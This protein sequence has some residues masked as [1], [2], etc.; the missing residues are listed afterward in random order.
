MSSGFLARAYRGDIRQ[1]DRIKF[2]KADAKIMGGHA[3]RAMG[4][5][6]KWLLE[7]GEEGAREV[8]ILRLMGLFDRPADIGCLHA[9]RGEP[10]PDLT[11]PIAALSEEDWEFA[12]TGL[13]KAKLLT[14]H[15]DASGALISLDAHPLLREYFA[16]RLQEEHPAA[17][18]AAHKRL[19]EHL[20][21]T[22]RDRKPEPTLA[23]LQPLYQAVAH[24]CAAG[25]WQEACDKV[26][27]ERI[28]HRQEFYS[29]NKLGAFGADLGA[30]ACFFD[31]PWSAVSP[32]LAPADQSWLLGQAAFRLRALGRLG[33]AVAPTQAGL[34]M[35]AR[36]ED[37][38]N[39]AATATNLSELQL[40]LGEMDAAIDR[41]E[42]LVAHA[43][44]SGEMF[45]RMVTRTAR[46]DALHQARR[47]EEATALFLYAEALQAEYEPQYPQL[48]SLRGFRYCDLLLGPIERAAWRRH[49]APAIA[50]DARPAARF[51]HE[52]G[53]RSIGS[54][55]N[56]PCTM[57]LSTISRLAVPRFM[58]RCCK[59]EAPFDLAAAHAPL[60]AAGDGLRRAGQLHY[61][62]RGLPSRA[63]LRAL[64]ADPAGAKE[65]LDEA[66]EI[67]T[68]GPMPLFLADIHLH[69]ARLFGLG[70][71]AQKPY[72]WTSPQADLTEARRFI[73]KHGYWRRKE[74]LEDAEAALQ[75]MAAGS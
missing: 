1:R 65:D 56:L 46:A 10:I 75:A 34:E 64:D 47:V 23:D 43:E 25:M 39:A 73:E 31:Q 9:L 60:Q 8:A 17:W 62:P 21:A 41:G 66:F 54:S 71:L 53:A 49:A 57:K 40:T 59:A 72:P 52:R 38:R 26:Y 45:V 27:W 55:E 70:P 18:R 7:G 29:T 2:D 16:A 48:Y 13:E 74:E 33:E 6:E 12:V 20:C 14:V 19:Y 42:E 61:L 36:K 28:N 3:F 30:V 67:A 68:R 44:R 11:E 24:G 15:R 22:T 58:P 32:A 4:A 37:W 35:Y 50:P 5:Y 63:M 51:P 69:R